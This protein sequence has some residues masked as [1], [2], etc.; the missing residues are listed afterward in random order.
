MQGDSPGAGM[1]SAAPGPL[2][3][4]RDG[5]P[6]EAGGRRL[7]ALLTL[8]LLDAGRAA[9]TEALVTGVRDGRPPGGVGNALRA[10]VSRLRAAL[11]ARPAVFA[12]GATPEAAEQV[13]GADVDVLGKL[14][15]KSRAAPARSGAGRVAGPAVGGPRQPVGGPAVGR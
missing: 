6:V 2:D 11:A 13:C 9:S 14:V 4:R 1:S 5:R 3:V 10:L 8:L 12:G 15:G 7:R